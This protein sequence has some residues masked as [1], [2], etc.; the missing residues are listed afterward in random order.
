MEKNLILILENS[1]EFEFIKSINLPKNSIIVCKEDITK[2][3]LLKLNYVCKSLSE[4][5]R[6]NDEPQKNG[7]AWIKTWPDKIIFKNKSFKELF[8]YEGISLF[9]FLEPRLYFYKISELILLIEKIKLILTQEKPDRILIKASK[10]LEYIVRVLS[11]AKIENIGKEDEKKSTVTYK[12]YQ[13]NLTL[14]LFL[15]KIFRGLSFQKNNSQNEKDQKILIISEVGNWRSEYDFSSNKFIMKDI[16]F[17]EIIKKLKQRSI[18][19]TVIDFENNPRRILNAQ[20]LIKKRSNSLGVKVVPWEKYITFDI[21]KKNKNTYKKFLQIW[22]EIKESESFKNSLYYDKILLHEIIHKD[23]DAL[24]KSFKALAALTLIET[25][26]VILNLVK[27]SVIIMH[28]EYGALQLSIINA[29]KKL[30]I[31]TISLQ[32]GLITD[33]LLPYVHK[34][35]HVKNNNQDLIFPLP[36]K[37]CVWSKNVKENLMR[38]G[39]FPSSIPIVTG[40]PKV[41]FLPNAMKSFDSSEIKRKYKIPEEKKIILFATENLPKKEERDFVAKTVISTMKNLKNSHLIIKPHPNETDLTLYTNLI[42]EQKL[43]ESSSIIK[44]SNL[45]ELLYISNLVIL[46]YSTVGVEA[47]R[48]NKPVISLNLMDLH[49]D[50]LMI[51]KNVVVVVRK[52]DELL[53]AIEKHLEPKYSKKLIEEGKIFAEK[54]LGVLDGKATERIIDQILQL[55]NQK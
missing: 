10:E 40:D 54:E 8:I 21:I 4:Y 31:P 38:F 34:P 49:D 53:P 22:N 19:V 50:A 12:S 14:K 41:D 43:T 47:M 48:M 42:E 46:S 26:K 25:S 51:R 55:K 52:I 5:S 17:S 29:A 28:D 27:P 30:G 15:L 45:Y 32:H 20:S 11:S 13:G 3:K 24:L 44:E 6:K 18:D 7:L 36:N 39:N 35:E 2:Q 33:N 37:M 1:N 23:I 16:F 9:W